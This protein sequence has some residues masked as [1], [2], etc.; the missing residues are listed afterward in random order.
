LGLAQ[1]TVLGRFGFM[2]THIG[3]APMP[4]A[5]KQN[6]DGRQVGTQAIGIRTA[7]KG[8]YFTAP[9]GSSW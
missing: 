1:F 9:F 4:G 2:T 5:G 7:S 8:G 6:P 3:P